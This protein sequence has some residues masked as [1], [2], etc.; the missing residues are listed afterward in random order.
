MLIQGSISTERT[1][2][3]N[4]NAGIS[5]GQVAYS[6][7]YT[8]DAAFEAQFLDTKGKNM[9]DDVT[10]NAIQ[11]SRTENNAGGKTIYIGG[12]INA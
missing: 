2:S 1:L 4:I 5:L 9:T 6:G 8:V 11:V 10:I 3:G 12:L 7:P